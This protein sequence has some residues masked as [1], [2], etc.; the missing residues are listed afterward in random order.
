MNMP[1]WTV[2]PQRITGLRIIDLKQS[3]EIVFSL[4]SSITLRQREAEK[5]ILT[6]SIQP[7]KNLLPSS[8]TGA[9]IVASHPTVFSA[10]TI[11][12]IVFPMEYVI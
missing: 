11:D 7:H 9:T 8:A 2:A 12:L 1:P 5:P 4:P 10:Q 6:T 3:G